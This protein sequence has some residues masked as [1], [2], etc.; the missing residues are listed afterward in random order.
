M[1]LNKLQNAKLKK[2]HLE[3]KQYTNIKI[4]A[5]HVCGSQLQYNTD[6]DIKRRISLLET[7]VTELETRCIGMKSKFV[8][9]IKVFE[10]FSES[11]RETLLKRNI[12]SPI[13]R[14]MQGTHRFNLVLHNILRWG[15]LLLSMMTAR[16]KKTNAY[17]KYSF[18]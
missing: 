14:Q 5:L 16:I 7:T 17:R 3:S 4:D 1:L 15:G 9:Q 18:G 2:K 13:F 10:L 12:R 6:I 8:K 11:K